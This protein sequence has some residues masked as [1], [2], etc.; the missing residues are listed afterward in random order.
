MVFRRCLG[1]DGSGFGFGGGGDRSGFRLVVV[2]TNLCLAFCVLFA[3]F[4]RRLN[5]TD[6]GL[7]VVWFRFCFRHHC[8]PCSGGRWLWW[9][10][11]DLGVR[12]DVLVVDVVCDW[13]SLISDSLTVFQIC[14]DLQDSS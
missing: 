6:L 13:F 11:W 12:G 14:R 7:E 1:G 2:E 9:W 4:L 8:L 5:T 3:G 10:S